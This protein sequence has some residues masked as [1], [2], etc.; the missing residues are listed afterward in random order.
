M[1]RA[2]YYGE[3]NGYTNRELAALPADIAGSKRFRKAANKQLTI[4]S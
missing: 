1:S 2:R 4:K 3:N